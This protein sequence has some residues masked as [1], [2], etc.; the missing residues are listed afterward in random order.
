LK[1][2]LR[3]A[4]VAILAF[5]LSGAAPRFQDD[6]PVY[7]DEIKKDFLD[8]V[9][10][11]RA[12]SDWKMLFDLQSQ[13]ANAKN[14]HKL[15]RLPGAEPRYVGLIEHLNR[16]YSDLPTE[17]LLY[18]RSQFDG[19]AKREFERAKQAGDRA[20]LEKVVETWF[21][22][23]RSDEALDLLANLH[24]E[25]GRLGMAIHCWSRL[26][27]H[28]PDSEVP[29]A[30]TAARLASAA[31][32]SNHES[33]LTGV[34]RFVQ[35]K[36]LGGEVIVGEEPVA[37]GAYLQSLKV[38]IPPSV[39]MPVVREP[40]ITPAGGPADGLLMGVRPEIRRWSADLSG[41]PD[42]A[43]RR[44]TTMTGDY[45][46]LPAYARVDDH[47]MVVY[48]NGLRITVIDPQRAT[49]AR[50][51]EGVYFTYPPPGETIPRPQIPQDPRGGGQSWVRPYIG[52]S[53][54]GEHAFAT[55]FS[56]KRPRE[57]PAPGPWGM[58]DTL[59]GT[60][61]LVCLNLRTQQVVWDTDFGEPGNQL[62]KLE[63]WERN[64]AFS[65]PPLIRGDRVYAGIGTSPML[66]EESRVVCFDRRSGHVVWDRFLASVSGG[67][68]WAGGG[69]TLTSRLTLLEEDRGVLIAHANVGVIAALDA[70]TGQVRWLSKYQRTSTGPNNWGQPQVFARPASPIV[71]HRG[72]IY[73]LPQDATDLLIAD[74][75]TGAIQKEALKVETALA[76][77]P[78]R[79]F[80]RLVG[81]MGDFLVFGGAGIDSCILNTATGSF[82]GLPSTNTSGMGRGIID[83][84]TLYLPSVESGRGGLGIFTGQKQWWAFERSII[85][86]PLQMGD[87]GNV[88]RA[89]NYLVFT[90]NS[91]ITLFTDS[92]L[93]RAQY[94][95]RLEQSP[96]SPGAWLD[97]GLLMRT[98]DRWSEAAKG[99]LKFIEAVQG[100]PEWMGR[101]REVRTEL[102]GIF[103]KLGLESAARKNPVDAAAHYGSAR[104]F[105]WD[106]PTLTEATRL[107]AGACENAAEIQSDPALRRSWA[108]RAVEE[109]QE[110]IRRS[111]PGFVRPGDSML[112]VPT[113]KYASTRIAALVR[114]HGADAYEGVSRAAGDELKKAGRAPAALR[115]M[116]DLYP[117]S[118]SAVEALDRIAELAAGQGRWS[119]VASALRE[120]RSRLGD[121]WTPGQQKRLHDALEKSGDGERLEMEL[122]R[123]ERTFEGSN[124]LG[125]EEAAPT[126]AE[127][128]PKARAAAAALARRPAEP[129]LGS[130]ATLSTW[131]APKPADDPRQLPIEWRLVVPDGL[132]P[133]KTS[134]DLEYF[135]RGS[136]IELWNIRTKKKI[137]SAPHPG[138]WTG[139]EYTST[140]NE[141]TGVRISEV[142]E[143]SP[144][145]KAGLEPGDVIGSVDGVAVTDED[146]DLATEARPAGT[147][148]SIVYKRGDETKRAEFASGPWPVAHR[149]GVIG[150][151]YT[152]EGTL[153]VAWEDVVA[154]FDPADGRP[155]WVSRPCRS[156]FVIRAIHSCAE[157]IL[158]HEHAFSDR[159]RSALRLAPKAGLPA[160][161]QHSRV[162]ALDDS[163][164][165]A[166]WALG[167][168]FD[169]ATAI[170]HTVQ[171]LGR[172]LDSH[173]G[174][175]VSGYQGNLKAVEVVPV[176][177]EDGKE[178][179]RI[180][181]SGSGGMP[182]SAWT[183]EPAS[184][185]LW[186]IDSSV[187]GQTKLKSFIRP[188]YARGPEM[189]LEAQVDPMATGFS[190][191]ANEERVA[192]L[193]VSRGASTPRLA[194]FSARDGTLIAAH[195]PGEGPLKDRVTPGFTPSQ[196][197]RKS[198][199]GLLAMEPDGTL[200]V[201]NEAKPPV[202]VPGT[203]RRASLTA[204]SIKDGAFKLEWDAITSTLSPQAFGEKE[205]ITVR[206]GPVGH[207]V[208]THRGYPPGKTDEAAVL[209]FHSR[210][211]EGA[212][213]KLIDDLAVPLDSFNY[214]RDPTPVHRGRIFLSR[215]G[216]LEI[217]GD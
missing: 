92:E 8:K 67:R 107:L 98:N 125:P 177:A 39:L 61:R 200:I 161:D 199:P 84:E 193:S 96:P 108:R 124:K 43:P 117:D 44:G 53:V 54:D 70:M 95:R 146:F 188:D 162:I 42:A 31:V 214:R 46:Y 165:E 89:G 11:S 109:Y 12:S 140:A 139:I 16:K 20:G 173:A 174:L 116:A 164:G 72:R 147:R 37:L 142:V 30:V 175:L 71:I 187:R 65:G 110:L 76:T 216:G 114:K 2:T 126:V 207:F 205:L 131:D 213:R 119:A 28:Y 93:V 132:E 25:E 122:S 128:L 10:R 80:Q 13:A 86:W 33:A 1:S 63:F 212:V 7:V 45:P 203:I 40:S 133:L 82:H 59:F 129:P 36:G 100:D 201:Y 35:E 3:L 183:V 179:N 74:L 87:S 69:G 101:A 77:R 166:V 112:W 94:R 21:Y 106:G 191:A 115:A 150:A 4:S 172:P 79:D 130:T 186:V 85:W 56:A 113:R 190:L 55:L 68:V 167:L 170:H 135:A 64:F 52:V 121:R 181:L 163:D 156:R 180:V 120:M 6:D 184:G 151:V 196:A 153:A 73:I 102:H 75:S 51:E 48:T 15:V 152:S 208:T 137:W 194:V 217:W 171:F 41:G 178:G 81:R 185:T 159:A 143:G 154:A 99:Y 38:E 118:V 192:V 182:G 210:K 136:A 206:G 158:V 26:L 215:A 91:K 47:E 83:G 168:R 209:S 88:I 50:P 198:L 138:G 141:K 123:M 5:T 160:E 27:Y 105:A 204:M 127:Y 23:T 111:P 211:E 195:K 202:G 176:A 104:D 14:V 149:P 58:P 90:S 29:R 169:S 19:V 78:W 49:S 145:A 66:E 144:A 22:S 24:V 18:Y 60:T 32:A 34:R 189:A 148:L 9:D 62:R 155:L 17:A 157:R 97:Y 197:E 103:L 57:A 134:A